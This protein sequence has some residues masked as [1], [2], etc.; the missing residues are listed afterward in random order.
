MSIQLFFIRF[1]N[2]IFVLNF[3]RYREVFNNQCLYTVKLHGG[4]VGVWDIDEFLMPVH[5]YKEPRYNLQ[6]YS[7]ISPYEVNLEERINVHQTI[8]KQL[9]KLNINRK[10]L[11]TLTLE[12]VSPSSISFFAKQF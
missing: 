9:K 11:C 10:Q 2:K 6:D 7:Q 5:G 8:E 3:F 4:L 12:S 1:F